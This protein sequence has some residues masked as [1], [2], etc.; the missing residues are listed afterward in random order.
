MSYKNS[1]LYAS[2]VFAEHPLA[3]WSI[4]ENFYFTSL[5]SESE[6][7]VNTTDWDILNG[8][9]VTSFLPPSENPIESSN[10]S[11]LYLSSSSQFV[12]DISGQDIVYEDKIDTEKGSVCIN[13][14]V[15]IP[16]IS[17]I[18]SI[19]SGFF[20]NGQYY[21]KTKILDLIDFNRWVKV[22]STT[23]INSENNIVP[24]IR[25]NYSE[26]VVNDE[27]N[28]SFYISGLSVGQWS[29]SYNSEDTG[30]IITS[31]PTNIKNLI[32]TEYAS[33]INGVQL[34]PYGFND[35]DSGYVIEFRKRLLAETS[36]IPMV[37]GSK[38]NV[39][40][41][42]RKT[43]VTFS[44]FI[45]G[46]T[47]S[48]SYT[49]EID[50]GTPSSTLSGSIDGGQTFIETS[51][52]LIPS[53]V[54]PGKGFLNKSGKY[55]NLTVEFWTRINNEST[56]PVR[57]FGPLASEDGI[58]VGGEFI[59]VK[60][61]KYI[62]SYFVGQWYRPMLLHFAQSANEIFLMINGEKVI[63]IQVDSLDISTFP[64]STEDYLA[65]YG[66]QKVLPF[67]MDS[68][69]IFPYIVTEQIAKLRF[70][71]GQGV[72][73]Q[74]IISTTFGGDL[75]YV[76]FP[77]AGYSSTIS[78]PDRTPWSSGYF[79]NLK[80]NSGGLSLP[81]YTLPDTI[82]T[83]TTGSISR[84]EAE[85]IWQGFNEDNYSIQD[86]EYPF[87]S[88]KPNESYDN[89]NSTILFS[90][91]N[92][93]SYPTKSIYG[94][95]KTSDNVSTEQ[96]LLYISSINTTDVFETKIV[97]GSLQ[98]LFNNSI[99]SSSAIS[100]SSYI[101]IGID[102]EKI[103]ENYSQTRTFFNNTEIL[104]LNFAGS[105]SNVFLGKIF[106]LT[107]NNQ[108]FTQKDTGRFN[109]SGIAQSVSGA[110]EYIGSYTLLPKQSNTTVFFDIGAT[111]YWETSVPMSYFGRYVTNSNGRK[112]YDLDLIQFNIDIPST[113]YSKEN[114]DSVDYQNI[115]KAKTYMTLQTAANVGTIPF[116]DYINTQTIGNDRVLD[117][118]VQENT[119]DTKFEVVDSTVIFP[120]KEIGNFSNYY[121]TTHILLT[122]TGIITENMKV[123]NM[124]FS[125]A[126]FDESAF[127]RINTPTGR[128]IYPITKS[129]DQYVYKRKNPVVIEKEIGSYFYN[130]G[131]S[132]I[133]VLSSQDGS[134]V[135]GLSFPIN[136][137]LKSNFRFV[138]IQMYLM[139][140]ESDL[141][142]EEK[143]FGKIF[144]SEK[145]YNLVV[146]P[147]SDSKR[148]K[149]KLIDT[150]TNQELSGIT[151]FLNGKKVSN[152]LVR[153]LRWNSI[154]ISLQDN[155]LNLSNEI[156]QL[157]IYSGVRV[158][159]VAMFSDINELRLNLT[160]SNDWGDIDDNIWNYYASA[161][162]LQV[163]NEQN[164][165]VTL[166]SV[167][168]EDIFDTYSGLSYAIGNDSAILDVNF[169]SIQVLND[170]NWT[171]FDIK[172]I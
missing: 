145:E 56:T 50:G 107:L 164:I 99:I 85:L 118:N 152:V 125:S 94:L 108:F 2:R 77:F 47:Y 129:N 88:L 15:Y 122:S 5:I 57:I 142:G 96:S 141:F 86:E 39:S 154:I 71:Y 45:D 70:A 76:S 89:I 172:P 10:V 115:S 136:E 91:L 148:G 16:D 131:N 81:D 1:N 114:Q 105:G 160:T 4:D 166:L 92:K 84:G 48:S 159:N 83:E 139:F 95:V 80:V 32:S 43:E 44:E 28:S 38:N 162:W 87:I 110:F 41:L 123:K 155:S 73:D 113:V 163:L 8:T 17:N 100:A 75:T 23:S 26:S 153:P 130:T 104:S 144:N 69:S 132:G 126:A 120:P 25:V 67:D 106:S 27:E 12:I 53:L 9:L 143:V 18:E 61:G 35:Q 128:S 90:K 36:G 135:K 64:E 72:E 134:L 30:A 40:I 157:E 165:P 62:K 138:G 58:Y 98:Y 101:P 109:E 119:N 11:K 19:D 150:E 59:T 22:E 168:G 31:V 66:Y 171:N 149:I 137:T 60:V 161:S 140:N 3:L 63:S 151:I 121:L 46:G 82:F 112:V 65:F 13:F 21:L 37:Y 156:G 54:F 7:T 97:S 116:T 68:F 102:I 52:T 146:E 133:Q 55:S 74:E 170:V 34:D 167:N 103:S 20:I 42:P 78:F 51:N 79:N 29:E 14:Y 169:D 147:E 158:N 124:S 117:L 127:Y 111:G 33:V 6:K 93:T 24:V 49:E